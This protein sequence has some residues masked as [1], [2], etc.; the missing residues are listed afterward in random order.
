MYS[1]PY[2]KDCSGFFSSH[3]SSNSKFCLTTIAI[4]KPNFRQHFNRHWNVERIFCVGTSHEKHQINSYWWGKQLTCKAAKDTWLWQKWKHIIRQ[5]EIGCFSQ[6]KV[7]NSLSLFPQQLHVDSTDLICVEWHLPCLC[8]QT[9]R[10][11]HLLSTWHVPGYFQ[12]PPGPCPPTIPTKSR[13]FCPA[14]QRHC[15]Y[16]RYSL[17]SDTSHLQEQCKCLEEKG[18]LWQNYMR[19]RQRNALNAEHLSQH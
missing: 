6:L 19:T 18:R 8:A 1:I 5:L 9:G 7:C 14:K 16:V 4:F 3:L 15:E 13:W 11:T 10:W 2:Q 17:S 12:V